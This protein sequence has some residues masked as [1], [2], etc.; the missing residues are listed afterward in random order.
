M[1]AKSKRREST[2][3]LVRGIET[4]IEVVIL[5][6]TYYLF[7]RHGYN[8]DS[9]F[10]ARGKYVLMGIYGIIF[11]AVVNNTDGFQFGNLRKFD[12]CLAQWVG[13]FITNFLTYFQHCLI[14]N[15]MITPM[16]IILLTVAEIFMAMVFIFLYNRIYH[17]TYAPHKMIMIFGTDEAVGL[18]IKLD[19][20]LDKYKIEKLISA[21]EDFSKI[22]EEIVKYEAVILND[23]PA[24]IRNDILKFCY[25][26]ELRVYVV[27]KITDV[28]LRGARNV[29]L[30]DTPI[31][32]VKGTGLTI[33]QKALKRLLDITLSLMAMILA[34]PIM[35]VVALAIKLEDGGPVFYRQ[36][37]VTRDSECFD[38]LKFRSMIVN[39]EASGESIPATGKDPRITKVG[40]IIRA[41]RIDELPQI[42]N[43]LKGDMSIVGPRPE[44]V[45]HVEQYT[46]EIP[47]FVYRLK[48]KGGLTGYAQI[49]GKYNTS[50]YDKL[51][52]D[53]MY[54][55][56]YSILL[57]L[58]L[59]LTTIRVMFQKESTE[60]FEKQAENE[61][62]VKELLEETKVDTDK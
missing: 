8:L 10:T 59:I 18:K 45:E 54:I 11:F 53:L 24:Q 44:R 26:N 9:F 22:C 38:I 55:E 28:I 6:V 17:N 4:F 13:I 51:R 46:K 39:A 3:G 21:E 23:V 36:K 35:L 27:P 2:K 31:F 12:L 61:K 43:I 37:R 14:Q 33:T 7:W 50:A 48:V 30:F 16:P 34:A 58:K 15:H 40:N 29:S 32:L 20:R 19:S 47:E 57:D 52:L 60:G 5:C 41:I 56:N 25:E 62:L 1:K 49:Y 42:F